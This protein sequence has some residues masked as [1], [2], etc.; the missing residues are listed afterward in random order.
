[1]GF[2]ETPYRRV[3]EGSVNMTEADVLYMS[4][5]KKMATTLHRQMPL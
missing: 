4:A 2:I 3:Q 1:M 5:E